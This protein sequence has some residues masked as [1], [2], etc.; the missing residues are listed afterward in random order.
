M[1]L[2]FLVFLVFQGLGF[3]QTLQGSGF[4]V[5][6]QVFFFFCGLLGGG[7]GGEGSLDGLGVLG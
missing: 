3:S 7:G 6:F 2:V 5:W 1:Y 4:R